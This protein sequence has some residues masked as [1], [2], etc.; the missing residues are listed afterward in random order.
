MK[1]VYVS[2]FT[3]PFSYN[4]ICGSTLL[5]AYLPVY[6][7]SYIFQIIYQPLLV[8]FLSKYISYNKIPSFIKYK[9]QGIL[10]PNHWLINFNNHN[11][12]N[13]QQKRNKQDKKEED[14]SLQDEKEIATKQQLFKVDSLI[15]KHMQDML[16]LITY[17]VCCPFLAVVIFLSMYISILLTRG[18]IG[19][20]IFQ[21][22]FHS[23][24]ELINKEQ[25]IESDL[26]VICLNESLKNFDY[27]FS[28]NHTTTWIIIWT[29]CFFFIVLCWDIAGDEVG[30][31]KSFWV[32]LSGIG[33]LLI[34]IGYI[35]FRNKELFLSL[36]LFF[37]SYYNNQ[38]KNNE[39]NK[40]LEKDNEEIV[41]Y[42]HHKSTLVGNNLNNNRSYD[43]SYSSGSREKSIELN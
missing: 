16:V 17:G 24:Q 14:E 5:A 43:S 10:W 7:Y 23:S 18:M 30:W 31:E 42:I 9:L 11:Y 38:Q 13:K 21:R 37:S 4:Y 33:A 12:N 32:P 15:T 39:S 1:E 36:Q 8:Y 27:S 41:N 26:G 40:T 28:Y 20:F 34:I 2:P 22:H 6:L 3:P 29:S 25:D 35:Q 19:R